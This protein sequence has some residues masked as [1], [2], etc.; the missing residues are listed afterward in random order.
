M[1]ED[2]GGPFGGMDFRNQRAINQ[3]RVL[4]QL[5]VI[6]LWISRLQRIADGIVLSCEQVVQQCQSD[7][8][9]VIEACE[10]DALDVRVFR[11]HFAVELDFAVPLGADLHLYVMVM[12]VELASIPPVRIDVDECRRGAE[13]WLAR[14]L[15]VGRALYMHAAVERFLLRPIIAARQRDLE[16]VSYLRPSMA[17]PVIN[18][19]LDPGGRQKVESRGGNEFVPRQQLARYQ[20]GTWLEQRVAGLGYS[21]GQ[22]NVASKARSRHSHARMRKAII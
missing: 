15:V 17:K 14:C 6:P 19:E 13:P 4:K 12:A 2:S 20:A 16:F 21:F 1:R 22:G 3:P 11:Q 8:P 7:P 10:I 18:L 5:F 9:I